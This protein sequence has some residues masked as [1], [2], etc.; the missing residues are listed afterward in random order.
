MPIKSFRGLIA[1]GAIDTITL[2]TNDGSTGY[3]IVKFELFPFKPGQ[4]SV[5]NVVT[6]HK[7]LPTASASTIEVDFSNQTL[8]AAATFHE[9]HSDARIDEQVSIFDNEIFNQD[10]YLTHTD[11]IG[12]VP[13]NYYIELEQMKLDL[14]E[15]T[16]ATLKDIRNQA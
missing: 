9:S 1:D 14:N 11:T 13:V 8:L 7:T 16:V 12:T 4:E 10:I 3:R 2:H 15:N 5:E 6:V